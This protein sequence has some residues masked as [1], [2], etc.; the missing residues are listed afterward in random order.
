[1]L[2]NLC[3]EKLESG[4]D[5]YGKVSLYIKNNRKRGVVC[6]VNGGNKVESG[7]ELEGYD[8][9]YINKSQIM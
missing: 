6:G 3:D 5:Y 8:M 4:W 2:Q 9:R 7:N 1:L